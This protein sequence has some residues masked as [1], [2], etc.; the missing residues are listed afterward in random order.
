MVDIEIRKKA[1]S[2]DHE[3]QLELAIQ[4]TQ[5]RGRNFKAAFQWL[6]KAGEAG[7]LYAMH[8]IADFSR[9]KFIPG[10]EDASKFWEQK[11]NREGEAAVEKLIAEITA[12][13]I[14]PKSYFKG[15]TKKDPIAPVVK[16]L[17]GRNQAKL[18][19]KILV[20]DDD[21]SIRLMLKLLLEQ[22]GYQVVFA[23]DGKIAL[24]VIGD[25]PDIAAVLC[26]YNLPNISGL[27]LITRIRKMKMLDGVPIV[28]VTARSD[29]DSVRAAAKV[30]INGWVVKPFNLEKLTKVLEPLLLKTGT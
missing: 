4:H 13:N 1:L 12:E 17:P 2:G 5:G 22:S 23:E 25:N 11:A 30:G 21:K 29:S 14:T 6:K 7:S 15:M 27:Q 8:K 24:D 9:L 18:K 20:V 10:G 16:T 3:A 28:M 19:A 26:D